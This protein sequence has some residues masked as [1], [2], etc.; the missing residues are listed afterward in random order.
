MFD[1]RVLHAYFRQ[2]RDL[3][4][5]DVIFNS[6]A[7]LDALFGSD[8]QEKTIVSS[9]KTANTST[10]SYQ[11]KTSTPSQTVNPPV[12][13]ASKENQT[14]ASRL[15]GLK[16]ID[17]LDVPLKPRFKAPVAQS[18]AS[19]EQGDANRSLEQSITFDQKRAALRVLYYEGCTKCALANTR[20]TYVFGEGR[21]NGPVMVIGEAPGADEDD[22][23]LPFVGAAGQLL[24][25]MLAA[26][27]LDRKKN[28]FIANVLKCRPPENRNPESSE[29]IT[30]L[31]IVKKQID[32][33]KPKA[34]LLLGRIAAHSL[35]STTD[36]IA[37]MRG[38]THLY[39]NIPSMVIYHPAALL[40]NPEYKRPAWED[41]QKFQKLLTD[42][43]VYESAKI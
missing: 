7:A 23:G 30:C 25:T 17:Q 24:N 39:N 20:K 3:S 38:K 36:S 4:M 14:I 37:A 18:A 32:I 10:S 31:P 15:S 11:I 40:R 43:G 34:I 8:K 27:G 6:K 26:I 28:V 41:L 42:L 19:P 12:S 9:P 13:S 1:K 33:I 35:L 29:I 5:P 16:T 21:A 2:Q 22:Q